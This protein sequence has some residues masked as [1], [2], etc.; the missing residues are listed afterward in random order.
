MT[1]ADGR[2]SLTTDAL[3]SY[4]TWLDQQP[5]AS[6]TKSS[7]LAQVRRYL[8]W[9]EGEADQATLLPD[10]TTPGDGTH[11]TVTVA[12]GD[13]KQWMLTERRL[14]P[15]TVNQALA[16]V[17]NFYRSREIL[18]PTDP[19]AITRQAPRPSP[20]NRSRRYAAT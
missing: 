15:R 5:L 19:V 11:R 1:P 12:V 8:G 17:Q 6:S 2:A 7:Y 16:A 4:S 14:A 18:I 10:H 9:L 3:N 13:Y 20:H